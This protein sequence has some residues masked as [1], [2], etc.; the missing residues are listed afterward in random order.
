MFIGIRL[1]REVKSFVDFNVFENRMLVMF[2]FV[3]RVWGCKL[4]VVFFDCVV[5]VYFF[6]LCFWGKLLKGMNF[7]FRKKINVFTFI[8]FCI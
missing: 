8:I 4:I 6:L 5:S 2:W 1:V 7:F 3:I